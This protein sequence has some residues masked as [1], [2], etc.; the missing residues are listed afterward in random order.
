MLRQYALSRAVLAAFL[1]L[2]A[3]CARRAPV[4]LAPLPDHPW[5]VLVGDEV[6]VRVYREPDLSGQFL[7]NTQGELHLPGLGQLSVEG[8]TV[9]SL[10]T[11]IETFYARRV[12]N[13]IVDVGIVRSL[14]VL[15]EVR[16]PGVYAAE[17]TWTVQQVIARAGGVPSSHPDVLILLRKGRDQS[18]YRLSADSR[19]DRLPLEAGDAIVAV[20]PSFFSR[21]ASQLDAWA[22]VGTLTT[23]ILQFYIIGRK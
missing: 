2:T 11:A 3:A 23:L 20:D 9:D 18:Q 21:N 12:V 4:S 7:V 17:P 13:A 14:P 22:R 16:A 8:L 19:L 1:L 10:T 6:R 15:G 5:T